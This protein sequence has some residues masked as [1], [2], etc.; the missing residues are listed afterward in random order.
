MIIDTELNVGDVMYVVEMEHV[1]SKDC[2]FCKG[3][4]VLKITGKN[5]EE[6]TVVCPKCLGRETT[7]EKRAV[8]K[9][10]KINSIDVCVTD[11]DGIEVTYRDECEDPYTLDPDGKPGLTDEVAFKT[12][13]EAQAYADKLNGEGKR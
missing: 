9:G 1:S 12:F 7:I 3:A 6:A 2:G 11:E 5:G 8:V 4:G 13:E 10:R